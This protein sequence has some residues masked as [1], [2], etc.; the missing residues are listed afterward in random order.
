MTSVRHW[1]GAGISMA[2]AG[3]GRGAGDGSATARAAPAGWNAV[4]ACATVGTSAVV[5]A[6][7]RTVTG[8]ELGPVSPPEGLKAG[9]SMC[10]FTLADGARMTVL[11]REAPDNPKAEELFSRSYELILK[12][13]GTEDF[14]AAEISQEGLATGALDKVIY[15]GL[16]AAIPP[17]YDMLESFF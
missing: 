3:C 16:E 11:T 10:T 9:F 6:T 12:V 2:L 15:G 5:K 13:F 4:D 14:R 8:T 7:G 17:N 1:L